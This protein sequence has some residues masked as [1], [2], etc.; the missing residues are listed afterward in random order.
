MVDKCEEVMVTVLRY[1]FGEKD[2]VSCEPVTR[3]MRRTKRKMHIRIDFQSALDQW[4]EIVLQ[5]DPLQ[6]QVQ[7]RGLCPFH[8]FAHVTV[9]EKEGVV[10]YALHL[11]DI[12]QQPVC[13][14]LSC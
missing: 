2:Y 6:A 3:L 8:Q 10:V 9:S 4:M 7:G 13:V 1:Q 12:D 14:E 11:K 5:F